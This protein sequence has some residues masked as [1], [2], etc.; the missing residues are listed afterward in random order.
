M[1]EETLIA[2]LIQRMD[3]ISREQKA[4]VEVMR[5][6]DLSAA[7]SRRHVHKQLEEHTIS[8]IEIGHRLGTVERSIEAEA[9]TWAEYRAL[10]A[11][12]MGA[13][14]LGKALWKAVAWLIG[15]AA[16]AT[17]FRHDIADFVR[18]LMSR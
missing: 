8:L 3:E 15:V 16:A 18:W 14:T 12:A 9:P 11:K 5:Q 17:A 13:G 7:E 6:S 4:I 10:K 2:L 1:P